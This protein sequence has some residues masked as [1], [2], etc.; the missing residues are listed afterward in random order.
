MREPMPHVIVLLPGILGS[1]LRCDGKI[2]WGWSGRVLARNLL[3]LG[4]D[5]VDRLS[6]TGAAHDSDSDSDDRMIAARLLPDLHLLPG[7]WKIDGYGAVANFIASEF[8]V[9]DG[10]NFFTFPYDWRLD[11]RIAARALASSARRWLH[12]WRASSGNRDAKLVL[13]A[14]SMGGLVS[15]YF[16]EVLDGWRDTRALITFGT[17]FRGSLNAVDAIANGVRALGLVDLSGLVRQLDSVYQLLPTYE[18]VD[19]GDGGL[20]RIADVAIPNAD[21]ARVADAVRFHEE[22]RRAVDAHG[23]DESYRRRGYRVYPI[24]GY[25]QTTHQTARFVDASATLTDDVRGA[26]P[27]GDGTVPRPSAIPDEQDDAAAAMF[28]STRHSSLQNAAAVL[29]HLGGLLSS[30]TLDL[31]TFRA[32]PTRL[33]QVS[34]EVADLHAFG[35]PVEVRARATRSDVALGATL[36]DAET[37]AQV[38]A[39][40]LRQEADGWQIATFTPPRAAA[41]RIVVSGT[42]PGVE[43][44]ADVFEV[45][46]PARP[47]S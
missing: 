35:E 36:V 29:T 34:L 28:A 2:V 8:D 13:V 11:N 3:T 6:V 26:S 17:P 12:D 32:V 4:G 1:E 43:P 31:G 21:P 38:A 45:V 47:E 7:F 39:L 5:L 37:G 18:C 25:R 27:G 9:T 14:H 16:L 40:P 33:A 23:S 22:I 42:G 20:R 46:S 15:R 44:A 10:R 41:Y 30:L 24:V 19:T